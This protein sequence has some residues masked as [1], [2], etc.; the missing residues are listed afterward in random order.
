[1]PKCPHCNST[2]V[3]LFSRGFDIEEY[4]CVRCSRMWKIG[5]AGNDPGD[6]TY[7]IAEHGGKEKAFMD[8]LNLHNYKKVDHVYPSTKFAMADHDIDKKEK[9]FKQLA[10]RK[11]TKFFLYPHA[12]RPNLIN[13][14]YP[15]CDL[16]TAQFVASKG[17]VEIMRRY[18]YEKPL[19]VVGWSF[20]PIRNFTP[21]EPRRVLFA[22]IHPK[23]SELDKNINKI[24]HAK[25]VDLHKHDKIKLTVRYLMDLEDAGID[26][27][28]PG[29]EY[30]LGKPDLCHADIEKSDLVIAHQTYGYIAVAMGK[31][32]LMFGEDVVP[33]SFNRKTGE[34]IYVNHYSS[35][36]DLLRYPFDISDYDDIYTLMCQVARYENDKVQEWKKRL[37]GDP[38]SSEQF[39]KHLEKHLE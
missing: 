25:L 24:T 7:I 38:F 29:I 32:T 31:P 12:G 6:K 20:S 27:K 4:Q 2:I 35:Y 9:W 11:I 10:E 39:M 13:D 14:I 15:S 34:P 19:E 33:H 28:E 26:K 5:L 30:I 21:T 8:A 17:H 23:M 37:I 16:T 36:K 3:R 22:P 1:M 18:G